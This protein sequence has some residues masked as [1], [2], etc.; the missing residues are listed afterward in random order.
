MAD[1]T[2]TYLGLTKPDNNASADTWGTKLNTNLDLI[3]TAINARLLTAGGTLTGAL[4]TVTPAAG[5]GGYAGVRY[6]HGVAPTTNLTNGDTWSTTAGFF[7][8]V[9]GATKTISYLEGAAFTGAVSTTSTLA[10]TGTASLGAVTVSSTLAVTGAAT[11]AGGVTL[12]DAS[13]DAITVTGTATFAQAIAA[14]GGVNGTVGSGTPAAGA[15]TTISASGA[16]SFNGTVAL[17]DAVGDSIAINAG[18]ATI[19]NGLSFSGGTATFSALQLGGVSV[20]TAASTAT[21]TGKTFDTAGSGNVLKVNGNT[22]SA[23]AGTATVT[24]PNSTGTVVYKDTTDTLTNKTLVAPALG[25]PASGVLTNCTGL[26]VGSLVG[27]IAIPNGGTGATTAAGIL[28]AIGTSRGSSAISTGYELAGVGYA[29]LSGTTLTDQFSNGYSI[30]RNSEGDFTITLDVAA[31]SAASWSAVIMAGDAIG[32]AIVPVEKTKTA[33]TLNFV[34]RR[35]SSNNPSE[36]NALNIM[37][38]VA[39]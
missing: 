34:T 19:P 30:A 24:F 21:L 5:A 8:R 14:S 1:T 22:L 38:F 29:T 37:I 31:A 10:V 15:F 25:T 3:D 11:F 2:T 9:N 33:S 16:V 13:G 28:T 27:T 4:I 26:P 7:H 35:G 39:S 32:Y 18:T 12:G 23:T 20:I 36:P 6:P 17:G